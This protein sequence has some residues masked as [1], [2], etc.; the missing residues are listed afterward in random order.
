MATRGSI[1]KVEEEEQKK[2]EEE[3]EEEKKKQRRDAADDCGS[4]PT[5]AECRR[6]PRCASLRFAKHSTARHSTA[7]ML[8]S[9]LRVHGSVGARIHRHHRSSPSRPSRIRNDPN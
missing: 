5:T 4:V 1:E 7:Q 9:S 6:G 3:E 8:A 2:Q